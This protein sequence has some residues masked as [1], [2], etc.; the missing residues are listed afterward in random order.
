MNLIKQIHK[1]FNSPLLRSVML[2]LRLPLGIALLV[3]LI[4]KLEPSNFWIGLAVSGFGAIFQLWCF[5]SLKTQKILAVHGPYMF[6]RNPMYIARFFLMLGCI[7][8][9]GNLWV[10]AIFCVLYYFYMVNRVKRE[11]E[12]LRK[13]FGPPYEEYCKKV[14]RFFPSFKSFDGK[15]LFFFNWSFFQRNHGLINALIVIL[16]YIVL[17]YFTFIRPV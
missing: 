1:I 11:E 12:K 8:M 16:C 15:S 9:T 14:N 17:Y 7:L 2:K 10:G 13:I 3:L 6:M 5:A 4:T